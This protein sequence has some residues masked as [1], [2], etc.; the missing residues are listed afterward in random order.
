MVNV[1]FND[2]AANTVNVPGA[3]GK[4]CP[5]DAAAPEVAPAAPVSLAADVGADDIGADDLGAEETADAVDKA[6]GVVAALA[7]EEEPL[8]A[9]VLAELQPASN[10]AAARAATTPPA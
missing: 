6:A 3:A 9:A 4:T 10:A 5:D 7:E 1:V 2:A 8:P